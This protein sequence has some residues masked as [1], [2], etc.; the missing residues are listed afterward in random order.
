MARRLTAIPLI[1]EFHAFA[2]SARPDTGTE[3]GPGIQKALTRKQSSNTRVRWVLNEAQ[4]R[5]TCVM[6]R[7]GHV[8][9]EKGFKLGIV[10]FGIPEP[11]KT[12]LHSPNLVSP[13][14][15]EVNT[16]PTQRP[17]SVNLR[18]CMSRLAG[19]AQQVGR[20]AGH[21]PNRIGH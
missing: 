10:Q 3:L 5:P 14:R 1:E 15:K 8:A 13:G 16:S 17:V 6:R 11:W 9:P 21:R 2:A 20:N 12:R 4:H 18:R 7:L 19:R